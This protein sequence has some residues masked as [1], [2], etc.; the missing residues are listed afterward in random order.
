MSPD[1][2]DTEAAATLLN[3]I[4]EAALI[5]VNDHGYTVKDVVDAIED[6]Q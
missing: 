2:D 4:V 6:A 3:E 5:L 1:D